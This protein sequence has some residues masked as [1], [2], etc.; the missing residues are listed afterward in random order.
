MVRIILVFFARVDNC[1]LSRL[2]SS[3]AI[4]A[5]QSTMPIVDVIPA[6]TSGRAVGVQWADFIKNSLQLR[7]RSACDSPFEILRQVLDDMFACELA[8][9]SSGAEHYE[10]VLAIALCHDDALGASKELFS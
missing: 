4:N 2:H 8:S 6:H 5:R 3:T 7:R 10:V 1:V 9:V